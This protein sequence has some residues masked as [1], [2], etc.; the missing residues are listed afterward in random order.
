MLGCGG[1]D[2]DWEPEAFQKCGNNCIGKAGLMF[3]Y[4]MGCCKHI[5]ALKFRLF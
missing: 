5:M 2:S 4:L 1:A 3:K